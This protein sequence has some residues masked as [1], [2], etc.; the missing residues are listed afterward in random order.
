MQFL[1]NRILNL[2]LIQLNIT[3]QIRFKCYDQILKITPPTQNIV[4]FYVDN[5]AENSFNSFLEKLVI[6][7]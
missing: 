2:I 7:N 6:V 1:N 3:F 5:F 4:Y